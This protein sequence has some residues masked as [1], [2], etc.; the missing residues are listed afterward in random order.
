MG[1]I[2][3]TIPQNIHIQYR[4]ENTARTKSLLDELNTLML[5]SVAANTTENRLLGLFAQEANLMDQVTE[6]AMQSRET[7]LLRVH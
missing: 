4:I 3:I 1:S 5:R 6:Q 7:D 2:T